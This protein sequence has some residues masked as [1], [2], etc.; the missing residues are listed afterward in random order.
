MLLFF[1]YLFFSTSFFY[2]FF[3]PW[4]LFRLVDDLE[5]PLS[6]GLTNVVAE[7]SCTRQTPRVV[8][9]C[10]LGMC[11]HGLMSSFFR[12][13]FITLGT[14]EVVTRLKPRL[15]QSDRYQLPPIRTKEVEHFVLYPR[16]QI[17]WRGL[18]FQKPA[19]HRVLRDHAVRPES[20]HA[21]KA[22]RRPNAASR[23]LCSRP[24]TL[25]LPGS[26]GQEKQVPRAKRTDGVAGWL[27][28]DHK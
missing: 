5:P 15:A 24:R 19:A 4:E 17:Q 23:S 26:L 12:R 3:L 1:F 16:L 28:K 6:V 22:T 13:W 21:L 7:L 14:L 10:A 18:V 9:A 2:L 20:V 11:R 8:T 27:R 25:L